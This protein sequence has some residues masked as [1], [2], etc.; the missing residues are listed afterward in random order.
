MVLVRFTKELNLFLYADTPTQS[1]AEGFR[2][3]AGPTANEARSETIWVFGPWPGVQTSAPWF[4]YGF[5]K[6]LIGF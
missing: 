2:I 1:Q 5:S 4:Q 3:E 6:V